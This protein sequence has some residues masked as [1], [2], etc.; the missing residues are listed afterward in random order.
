MK[1]ELNRKIVVNQQS[2]VWVSDTTYIQTKEG[3]KYITTII[4]LYDRKIVGWSLSDGMSTDE[5]TLAS[6][7]M[8]T[9]N[10]NVQA[11]FIFHF[12]RGVQYANNKFTNALKSYK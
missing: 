3:F 1:N 5:T 9:W 2:K 7:K 10:R 4:D 8:T 6:W 12:D 11:D